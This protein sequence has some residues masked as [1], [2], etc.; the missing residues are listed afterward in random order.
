MLSRGR[1]AVPTG[2]A[3]WI[4]V[5]QRVRHGGQMTRRRGIRQ[6]ADTSALPLYSAMILMI[7]IRNVRSKVARL[8]LR[9]TA[10]REFVRENSR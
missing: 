4:T 9:S 10:F 8:N 7:V 2:T 5:P 3:I 6:L 1:Y